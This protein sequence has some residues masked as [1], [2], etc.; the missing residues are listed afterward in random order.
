MSTRDWMP[1]TRAA[2]IAMAKTWNTVIPSYAESWGV[3]EAD[4]TELKEAYEDFNNMMATP[5]EQRTQVFTQTI[6]RGDERLVAIM[7]K[8]KRLYLFP[9]IITEEQYMTLGLRLHDTEPTPVPVPVGTA[10]GKISYLGGQQIQLEMEHATDISPEAKSYYGFRIYYAVLPADIPAPETEEALNKSV[11]TRRRRHIF[12]F[13]LANTGKKAHFRI[14]YEN[15]KG[16]SGP[17]GPI[18]S[19][20]I[21]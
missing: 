15:S 6:R 5:P 1:T 20:L 21:P 7:R 8:L 16:E 18:V 13:P 3:P 9:E 2:R 11:F 4:V 17:F 14:V 12:R 19:T 10:T